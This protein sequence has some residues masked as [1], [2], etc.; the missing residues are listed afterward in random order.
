M[1]RPRHHRDPLNPDP[2][3]YTL[4]LVPRGWAVPCHLIVADGLY[5]CVIDGVQQP[6]AW[7]SDGLADL[8]ASWIVAESSPP[9]VK[10]ILFGT[11]CSEA[12]FD[13][14]NSYRE[15]AKRHQPRHPAANPNEPINIALLEGDEF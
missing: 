11:P 7:R 3:F 9:I 2:G 12:E 15:W 4:R 5:S 10:L 13:H 8:F 6:G 1:T 14:K